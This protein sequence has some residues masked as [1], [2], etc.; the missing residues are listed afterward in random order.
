MLV[1]TSTQTRTVN[2]GIVAFS[3]GL[4]Q[5]TVIA[6]AVIAAVPTIVF[7]LILQKNIIAGLT[8]GSLK[9]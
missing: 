1:T 5:N 9:G 4:P 6:A 7:F 8:A 2:V 3:K